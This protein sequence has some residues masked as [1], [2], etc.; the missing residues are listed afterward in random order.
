MTKNIKDAYTITLYCCGCEKHVAARLTSG[1]E[2][3]PHRP[4][5]ASVP[6]WKCDACGNHVGTHHKTEN[7]TK[8][9]GCIP[10]PELRTHRQ[11]IHSVID[12][13]WKRV[14]PGSDRKK[15]R[16][17]IYAALS[18]ALGYS[19]HSAELRTVE[20]ALRVHSIALRIVDE[21]RG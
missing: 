8:P 5:L 15:K 1:A 3:Y 12:P 20:E 14:P 18:S 11:R 17:Q 4:D 16:R 9:L 7:P 10:T 13:M 19:F 6:R 21:L 2:I